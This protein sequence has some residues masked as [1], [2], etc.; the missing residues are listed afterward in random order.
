M[1]L[2]ALRPAAGSI[3]EV[4]TTLPRRFRTILGGITALATGRGFIST[5]VTTAPFTGRGIG[6]V[7]KK[8]LD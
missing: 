6:A 3:T 2:T 4:P 1:G 8:G 5:I 7:H